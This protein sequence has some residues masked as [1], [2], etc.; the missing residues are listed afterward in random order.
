[1]WRPEPIERLADTPGFD[2]TLKNLG[3]VTPLVEAN[4]PFAVKGFR[5]DPTRPQVGAQH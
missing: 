3:Q 5:V 4:Q 1:M 2:R